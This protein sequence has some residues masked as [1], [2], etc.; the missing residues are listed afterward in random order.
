MSEGD[1]STWSLGGGRIGGRGGTGDGISAE[2]E[3]RRLEA[4]YGDCCRG[5]RLAICSNKA[6]GGAIPERTSIG[7]R[8]G[9]IVSSGFGWSANPPL[10]EVKTYIDALRRAPRQANLDLQF[11][12]SDDVAGF[13]CWTNRVRQ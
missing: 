8:R 13:K 5:G 12:M 4:V 1:G 11:I 9:W 3:G 2:P 7:R 10:Y 6:R